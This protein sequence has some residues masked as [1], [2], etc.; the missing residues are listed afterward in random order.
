[1]E[2]QLA[3]PYNTV[4]RSLVLI[5]TLQPLLVAKDL[6]STPKRHRVFRADHGVLGSWTGPSFPKPNFRVTGKPVRERDRSARGDKGGARRDRW[7]TAV[8]KGIER[9]LGTVCPPPSHSG[10]RPIVPNPVRGAAGAVSEWPTI[11]EFAE[12]G[13]T[14]GL[15]LA[16]AIRQ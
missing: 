4:Y 6:P 3:R 10:K 14:Y 16:G 1:M 8:P 13:S 5:W 2:D 9:R 12:L 15:Y 11:W 7:P